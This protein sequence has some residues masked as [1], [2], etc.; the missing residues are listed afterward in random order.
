M[1][2][3]NEALKRAEKDKLRSSPFFNNFTVLPPGEDDSPPPPGAAAEPPRDRPSRSALS[4]LSAVTLVAAAAGAGYLWL[5]TDGQAGPQPAA[6]SSEPGDLASAA[7]AGTSPAAPT[8]AA[9]PTTRPAPIA[10]EASAVKP[11][12]SD[13]TETQRPDGRSPSSAGPAPTSRPTAAPAE[14]PTAVAAGATDGSPPPPPI[15]PT[16]IAE[17]RVAETRP[18]PAPKPSLVSPRLPAGPFNVRLLKLSVIMR[19]PEG[20]VALINGLPMEEGQTVQGARIV[21]IGQH[22][23]ELEHQG[24]TFLLGM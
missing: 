1:S 11:G 12:P 24:K 21:R 20:N 10:P 9:A 4:V 14:G 6:A 16:E 3:I 23:V 22:H 5:R 2:L 19:G 15:Q 8:P 17:A 13:R 7:P 18:A